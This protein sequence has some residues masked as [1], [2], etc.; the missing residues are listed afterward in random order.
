ML[1]SY[2]PRKVDKNVFG[3]LHQ[4]RKSLEMFKFE[5]P[6]LLKRSEWIRIIIDMFIYV[7]MQQVSRSVN[8]Y[9][10]TA[11]I[12]QCVFDCPSTKMTKSRFNWLRKIWNNISR[13][14]NELVQSQSSFIQNE[15]WVKW[16]DQVD[17][18]FASP[19]VVIYDVKCFCI[20]KPSLIEHFDTSMTWTSSPVTQ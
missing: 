11:A 20:R 9:T 6:A 12:S 5:S 19:S 1:V 17:C 10:V 3:A 2:Q 16:T 8:V 18:I 15:D 13:F 4:L 7:P 14:R